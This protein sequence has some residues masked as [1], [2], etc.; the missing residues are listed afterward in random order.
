L[1]SGLIGVQIACWVIGVFSTSP[2][3]ATSAN[4]PI[5]I[6]CRGYYLYRTTLSRWR[7]FPRGL[8]STLDDHFDIFLSKNILQGRLCPEITTIEWNIWCQYLFSS[9]IIP[10]TR[11]PP[12]NAAARDL[13]YVQYTSIFPATHSSSMKLISVASCS[14][15]NIFR[16]VFLFSSSLAWL[17]VLSRSP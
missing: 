13:L 5:E 7:N 16:I 1:P 10:Q 15:F 11:C 12:T 6:D 2:K 17:F 4:C 14:N 3:T 9:H 8:G